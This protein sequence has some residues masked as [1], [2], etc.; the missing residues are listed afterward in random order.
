MKKKYV[1][2]GG[3]G[4]V[5]SALVNLLGENNCQIFDKENSLLFPK[6]TKIADVRRPKQIV[7]DSNIDSLVLLAAEHRDDISPKSLYYDVN[8]TGTVNILNKMDEFNIKNLIFTSS[9]AIYGLNKNNPDENHSEDAFNDYGKSK[10]LAEQEIKKWYEKDPSGKS[11]TIIRPTVI[12]GEGNRGNVYNLLKQMSLG[13]FIMIGDGLNKKSMAY[14]GNIVSFIKNKLEL[15]EKGYEIYNYADKPD[16]NMNDLTILVNKKMNLKNRSFYL[17]YLIGIIIGYCFDF[18][19]FI[20][21][22]NLPISS[23]RIKK[24]C[25]TT[26]FN[27][28]KAHKYFEAPFTLAEGINNTLDYEFHKNQTN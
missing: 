26:E 6:I 20:L 11:V 14:I 9:V 16:F 15:N 13:K 3:S 4:F 5:G 12:F 10:W 24:F 22:K 8:V 25:A 27:S 1:L 28:D 17:P 19:S 7:F 23:V 2:V 18:L 21:R